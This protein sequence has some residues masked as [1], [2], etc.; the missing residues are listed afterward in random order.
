MNI[1]GP[2]NSHAVVDALKSPPER[3]SHFMN[4][5]NAARN[6]C[7]RG[8]VRE[9]MQRRNEYCLVIK[10]LHLACAGYFRS[11]QQLSYNPKLR[12]SII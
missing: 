1:A 6:K 11:A 8:P 9:N 4:A 5:V 7:L 12:A 10:H 3:I 2:G